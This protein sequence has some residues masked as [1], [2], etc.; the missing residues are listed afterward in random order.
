VVRV[1]LARAAKASRQSKQK[2]PDVHAFRG[3]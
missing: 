2:A 3:F 1:V